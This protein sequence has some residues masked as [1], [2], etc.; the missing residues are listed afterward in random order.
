MLKNIIIIFIGVFISSCASTY[1]CGKSLSNKCRSVTDNYKHSYQNTINAEDLD[2]PGIFSSSKKDTQKIAMN[3]SKYPQIPTD[4]SPLVSAPKMLRVWLTPYKDSDNIFHEQSYEYI[5][6]E[7]S[8][9]VFANNK[10]TNPNNLNNV[11]LVQGGTQ[12]KDVEEDNLD[13][14]SNPE[15]YLN[16]NSTLLNV[17]KNKVIPINK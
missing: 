7:Q 6:V 4:G 10:D 17:I 3:F 15:Q 2:K 8:D 12:V 14:D 9:W 1:P 5:I 16:D 13:L 11:A